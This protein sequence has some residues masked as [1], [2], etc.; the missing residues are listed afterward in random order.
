MGFKGMLKRMTRALILGLTALVV[1]GCVNRQYVHWEEEPAEAARRAEELTEDREATI[2]LRGGGTLRTRS[3]LFEADSLI[4]ADGT[5]ERFA[6]GLQEI[7]SL[8]VFDLRQRRTAMFGA[9]LGAVIVGIRCTFT[10][11][12]CDQNPGRT[13]AGVVAYS[14]VGFFLG[15]F[16][17]SS[18]GSI[19]NFVP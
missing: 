14:S 17:G 1:Q 16:L 8:T 7:D 10:D 4:W 11:V 12:I 6:L 19:V 5:G 3:T 9:L 2:T 15:L 18:F 13:L